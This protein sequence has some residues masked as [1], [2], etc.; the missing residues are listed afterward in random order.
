[1][2]WIQG[3]LNGTGHPNQSLT[4]TTLE[5]LE[6]LFRSRTP[7]YNLSSGHGAFPQ[8]ESAYNQHEK[9]VGHPSLMLTNGLHRAE[10]VGKVD[11][12]RR[13]MEWI[14][15][16]STELVIQVETNKLRHAETV[17]SIDLFQNTLTVGVYYT[18]EPLR[19]VVNI[20]KAH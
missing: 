19:M 2:G 18:Y 6:R 11:M 10:A 13:S 9:T 4:S 5:L 20:L 1:M 14:K 8:R 17:G 15:G 16:T 7:T 3:T 12:K